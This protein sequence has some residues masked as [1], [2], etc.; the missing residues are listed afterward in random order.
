MQNFVR[1]NR[2]EE[3]SYAQ[4]Q[5]GSSMNKWFF[6]V[7]SMSLLLGFSQP[8]FAGKG[9]KSDRVSLCHVSTD[10][11]GGP[12]IKLMSVKKT[13]RHL[14]NENHVWDD[15]YD[16]LPMHMGASGEGNQ[17]SNGNGIDDG[18]EVSCPCWQYSELEQVPDEP[19]SHHPDFYCKNFYTSPDSSRP[20]SSFPE[21][22]SIATRQDHSP[23]VWFTA[24]VDGRNSSCSNFPQALGIASIQAEVCAAEIAQRC[25]DTGDPIDLD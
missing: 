19:A 12:R 15:V 17:D 24:R 16:Y 20:G 8:V 1:L 2:A 10:N 13:D 25:D 3:M 23:F 11:H 18:C 14:G 7:L 22:S 21:W 5:K 4:L 9:G 6:L